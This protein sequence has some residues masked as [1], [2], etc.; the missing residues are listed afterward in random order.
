MDT[1]EGNVKRL[2]RTKAELLRV[3]QHE[4]DSVNLRQSIERLHSE[5]ARLDISIEDI[6]TE[7]LPILERSNFFVHNTIRPALPVEDMSLR[8]ILLAWRAVHSGGH[9]KIDTHSQVHL[10][11]IGSW[12]EWSGSKWVTARKELIQKNGVKC[13]EAYLHCSFSPGSEPKTVQDHEIVRDYGRWSTE[14]KWLPPLNWTE[15]VKDAV[16]SDNSIKFEEMSIDQLLRCWRAIYAE[17]GLKIDT[18]RYVPGIYISWAQ[19]SGSVWVK[20]LQQRM[21]EGKVLGSAACLLLAFAPGSEPMTDQDRNMIQ[22]YGRWITET[23]W[24]PPQRDKTE[25]IAIEPAVPRRRSWWRSLQH[26]A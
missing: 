22:K 1:P 9:L 18:T 23:Q 2:G 25:I 3:Y 14:T 16:V 15:D 19:W 13:F 5:A 26:R 6:D 10:G 4:P 21:E 11:T 24:E 17:G 20:R 8:D 12:A 7:A